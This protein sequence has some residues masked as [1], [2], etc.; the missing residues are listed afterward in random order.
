[1]GDHACFARGECSRSSAWTRPWLRGRL[2]SGAGLAWRNLGSALHHPAATWLLMCV[3][4]MI[5]IALPAIRH[6]AIQS[7]RRRRQRAI[8]LFLATYL[9]VWKG[10][11][12]VVLAI[13][14]ELPAV[15]VSIVVGLCAVVAVAWQFT[16]C[17]LR[18]RRACH[19]TVP[20]PTAGVKAN[21][22]CLRFGLR[23]SL[24]CVGVCWPLMVLMALLIDAP[25]GW[26]VVIGTV[27]LAAKLMPRGPALRRIRGLKQALNFKRTAHEASIPHPTR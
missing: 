17:Q 3:A 24:A 15:V 16:R 25:V 7:L 6:T 14:S 12:L 10:F 22:A 8:A 18:F 27:M 11:G 26:M 4:V 21:R 19:G 13:G 23:H 2:S 1:M 9:A 5:P 20:L